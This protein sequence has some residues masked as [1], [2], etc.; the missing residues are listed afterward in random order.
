MSYFSDTGY[1]II[2]QE[3]SLLI[4]SFNNKWHVV[5]TFN[6]PLF[7]VWSKFAPKDVQGEHY[8]FVQIRIDNM[9]MDDFGNLVGGVFP[10][11]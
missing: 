7:D 6:M 2:N 9:I 4:Y 5:R 1:A 10:M 8:H 11:R 3:S